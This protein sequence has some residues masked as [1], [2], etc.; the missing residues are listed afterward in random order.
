ML[1]GHL[2][3]LVLSILEAGSGHG[4][5]ILQRLRELSED[6]LQLKEGSLY[7]ALYRLEEAGLVAAKWDDEPGKSKGP[8][9][10]VY[11]ITP[12]G[13]KSLDAHRDEW[14]HFSRVIGRILEE[15]T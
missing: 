10:R 4:Y 13:R 9:R 11:S 5:D 3:G 8:R 14:R 15:P 6:A 2:D 7:P 12:K 1:R